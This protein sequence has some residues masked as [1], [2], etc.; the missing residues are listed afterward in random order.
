[1]PLI[2]TQLTRNVDAAV[3]PTDYASGAH[4]RGATGTSVAYPLSDAAL[5]LLLSRRAQVWRRR[6]S[7]YC[8]KR[9]HSINFTITR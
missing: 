2:G 8:W 4:P 5:E 1:M 9:K 6:E 3:V 7:F